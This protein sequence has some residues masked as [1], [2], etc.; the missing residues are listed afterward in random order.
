MEWVSEL[1]VMFCKQCGLYQHLRISSGSFYEVIWFTYAQNNTHSCW[2]QATEAHLGPFL[3]T[4]VLLYWLCCTIKGSFAGIC[5]SLGHHIVFPHSTTTHLLSFP[6]ASVLRQTL[7]RGLHS[8]HS[9]TEAWLT[10]DSKYGAKMSLINILEDESDTFKSNKSKNIQFPIVAL[11]ISFGL[12]FKTVLQWLL[13]T[14]FIFLLKYASPWAS[15]WWQ[16]FIYSLCK[17]FCQQ[18]FEVMHQLVFLCLVN[19]NNPTI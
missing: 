11:H 17:D 7:I 5:P 1:N 8:R 19:L 10:S 15:S 18:P 2:N 4:L 14:S 6:C 9:L 3:L 16:L 13:Q 12:E